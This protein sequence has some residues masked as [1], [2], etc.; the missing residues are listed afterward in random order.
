VSTKTRAIKIL[1]YGKSFP[2][3]YR[4]KVLI[5][6]LQRSQYCISQFNPDFY[7]TSNKFLS[8][9]SWVEL[10]IKAI[11][12]DA[13]YL[14]PKNAIYIRSAI[15]AAKLLQKKL[16]VEMHISL[17]DNYVKEYQTI[18]DNDKKARTLKQY[19]ILALTRSD[20]LIHSA[21]YELAYWEKILGVNVD[22]SKVFIAPNCN[23]SPTLVHQRTFMQDGILRICWWGTFIPLHGLDKILL[24]MQILKAKGVKFTCNL[25]GVDRPVFSTYAEKIQSA[26]L[27]D[28]VF[29]RK[30]LNFADGS[31]PKYLIDN[32]DLALGI[33]GNGDAALHAMPNKLNEALAMSIPT[34]TMNAPALKEFF[35]PETDFWTCEPSSEAIVASVLHVINGTAYPVDWEQ[36]RQKVINT[37]SVAR[38]QEVLKQVLEKATPKLLREETTNTESK[39]LATNRA[40]LN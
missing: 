32:C 27:A 17:Y 37:F 22:R 35:N 8:I 2:V 24:A 14:L 36:T 1:L 6:L 30:D 40:V 26:D 11:F 31:L 13:I 34:L 5:D 28:C 19:D 3:N 25:F 16:I 12:A 38:Y 15:W 10:F 39:V 29:L 21:D 23:A 4:S 33:F 20:Y 9:F 18:K 7:W